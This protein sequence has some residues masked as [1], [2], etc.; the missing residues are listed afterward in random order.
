MERGRRGARWIWAAL[1][2]TTGQ[3]GAL[4][5]G[6]RACASTA[7]P[8]PQ[9]SRGACA[10]QRNHSAATAR[11]LTD[12]GIRLRRRQR[13]ADGVA[14]SVGQQAKRS[15]QGS[16]DEDGGSVQAALHDRVGR[17]E[18]GL[19]DGRRRWWASV[20]LF[21]GREGQRR[22]G[23]TPASGPHIQQAQGGQCGA[24]R[25]PPQPPTAPA[26]P[27]HHHP[28]P[29]ASQPHVRRTHTHQHP[30]NAHLQAGAAADGGCDDLHDDDLDEEARGVGAVG[31]EDVV[32]VVKALRSHA[33]AAEGRGS[34]AGKE[35]ERGGRGPAGRAAGHAHPA[36]KTVCGGGGTAGYHV[37]WYHDIGTVPGTGSR[38]TPV[39]AG[40]WSGRP[41]RGSA[42]PQ[43]SSA[44]EARQRPL[45]G[46]GA[47]WCVCVSR[48]GG[49]NTCACACVPGFVSE[50]CAS[51]LCAG[52]WACEGMR[53][54]GACGRQRSAEQGQRSAQRRRAAGG[55]R[56]PTGGH[57]RGEGARGGHN[58][59][60]GA[61]GEIQRQLVQRL[62]PAGGTG[63]TRGTHRS[64]RG[65]RQPAQGDHRLCKRVGGGGWGCVTYILPT[66]GGM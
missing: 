5:Q 50:R 1:Q 4:K 33:Y 15:A 60:D 31:G 16:S 35:L 65:K 28:A 36:V 26:S 66:M 29:P 63:G 6:P 49:G 62:Q 30:G 25:Q 56:R 14:H 41:W 44:P 64:A 27:R 45:Q 12:E 7:T 37:V 23:G 10:A 11:Q 57:P 59:A 61:K 43:R 18:V 19:G 42:P 13:Q 40:L 22:Q 46:S 39:P 51:G 34:G 8:Q 52:R 48:G 54:R 24:P 55:G 47:R 32:D 38:G 3:Q 58:A 20:C 17:R 2:H 53:G 21:R 9:A